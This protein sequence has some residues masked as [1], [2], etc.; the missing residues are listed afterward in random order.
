MLARLNERRA[1]APPREGG[2]GARPMVPSAA[3]HYLFLAGLVVE[4]QG[5]SQLA[6]L[7]QEKG[8]AVRPL[9]EPDVFAGRA[10]EGPARVAEQL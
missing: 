6:D 7:V 3:Q 9:E 8:P 2:P 1:V 5:P 4:Q 10:R